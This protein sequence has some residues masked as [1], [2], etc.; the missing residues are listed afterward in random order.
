[1]LK[2]APQ[3][4]A[5]AILDAGFERIVRDEAALSGILRHTA[6]MFTLYRLAQLRPLRD[7]RIRSARI[8]SARVLA[9]FAYRLLRQ[10]FAT[11]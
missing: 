3:Q 11:Y 9:L 6:G 7:G 5:E 8:V 1:L 10:L 2:P 4:E